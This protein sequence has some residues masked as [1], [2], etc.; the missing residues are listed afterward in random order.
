LRRR[1]GE[2]TLTEEENPSIE[3]EN[4]LLWW[5]ELKA[6]CNTLFCIIGLIIIA[7]IDFNYKE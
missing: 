3:G 5:E 4:P 2:N 7:I 6:K 1:K